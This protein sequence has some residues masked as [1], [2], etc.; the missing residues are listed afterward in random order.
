MEGSFHIQKVTWVWRMLLTYESFQENVIEA[1]KTYHE[2]P[3][4]KA[5]MRMP[6]NKII[7]IEDPND[8]SKI[9]IA[10][11]ND[12]ESEVFYKLTSFRKETDEQRKARLEKGRLYAAKKR[13]EE[14]SEQRQKRLERERNSTRRRRQRTSEDKSRSTSALDISRTASVEK[15]VDEEPIQD[16][17]QLD[18]PDSSQ[19]KQEKMHNPESLNIQPPDLDFPQPSTSVDP[20]NFNGCFLGSNPLGVQSFS[21]SDISNLFDISQIY[22]Q[23]LQP[24]V[25]LAD[26]P[27]PTAA[28]TTLKDR[29]DMYLMQNFGLGGIFTLTLYNQLLQILLPHL[30]RQQQTFSAP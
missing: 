14:S 22:S 30:F 6:G 10:V 18:R 2:D 7:Q 24:S 13:M 26:S 29:N 12:A 3:E 8:P 9:T 20:L 27:W 4:V 21:N 17:I 16:Q 1:L 28:E 19:D 11:V 25:S 23:V 5:L 15:T